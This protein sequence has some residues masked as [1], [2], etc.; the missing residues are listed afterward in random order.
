MIITRKRKAKQIMQVVP[1][2]K[3]KKV[4]QFIGLRTI[5]FLEY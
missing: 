5:L 4:M 2:K 1:E 3:K